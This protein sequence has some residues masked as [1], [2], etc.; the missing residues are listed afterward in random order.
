MPMLGK[1]ESA[2]VMQCSG[3]SLDRGARR[4]TSIRSHEW[5]DSVMDDSSV[6]IEVVK[7]ASV[8]KKMVAARMLA[9]T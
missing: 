7:A 2:M 5:K 6:K 9:V 3:A 4:R 8:P 1:T